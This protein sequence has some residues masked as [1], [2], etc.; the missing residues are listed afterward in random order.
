MFLK[1]DTPKWKIHLFFAS[2]IPV[3]FSLE[4]AIR[5]LTG[6]EI[7]DAALDA[8]K[9]LSLFWLLFYFGLWYC[10]ATGRLQR[11]GERKSKITTL[12]LNDK[13]I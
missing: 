1:K 11:G 4:F 2:L 6:S 10:A 9:Q 13:E 12:H 8:F 7:K 3:A 5:L